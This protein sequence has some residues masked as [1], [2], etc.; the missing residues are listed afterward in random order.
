MGASDRIPLLVVGGGIGG[1]AAALGLAR[2]GREVHVIE[3][4]PEFGEIG[5]GLQLAPN[6]SRMLDRLGVL[7]EIHKDAVFPRR[8]VWMDAVAGKEITALDLGEKFQA[9]YGYPYVVMHRNDLLDALLSACRAEPRVTLETS[10]DVVAVEETAGG[11]RV[12]CADGT[13]YECGTLIGADGLWS[14]TRRLVVGDGEPICSQYVA[15][16]GAIP[17]AE[18]SEH[19]GLDNVVMW[20]GPE[21]HFV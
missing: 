12:R 20:V 10:K 2:K 5:A 11:A 14:P 9:T 8:L 21:M 19:A 17:M 15:Y 7:Q 6:A 13:V 4:A 16:R 18:M 1:L 3:K